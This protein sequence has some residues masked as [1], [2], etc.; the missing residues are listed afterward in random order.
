MAYLG[1]IREN[2]IS[3]EGIIWENDNRKDARYYWNGAFIDLCD[4]PGEDYAKTIFVTSGSGS[5]EPSTP[6]KVQNPITVQESTYTDENGN[7]YYV[8][9]AVSKQPV[10]SNVTIEMTIQDENGNE[11]EVVL[12]I[13]SGS[14]ASEPHRTGMMMMA[15]PPKVVTSDHNPKEDDK[16]EYDTVLP[17]EPIILPMAYS[18]TMLSGKIDT[19]S[20]EELIEKLMASGKIAMKDAVTSENFTVDFT[21][22]PVDGLETMGVIELTDA[23]INNASDI[24]LVT[25]K[26][27]KSIEQAEVAGINE[28][29]L[30]TKR[31]GNVQI[32][33]KPYDVWYKRDEGQTS[34][35][36]IC[37]SVNAGYVVGAEPRDYIIY[38]DNIN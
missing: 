2:S 29:S 35:S 7:T 6:S 26:A 19:I 32:D 17:E 15:R 16:F 24:I 38:Y 22:I 25:D 21:P 18:I 37:D 1:D 4:L 12:T 13:P 31:N 3:P 28:I 10:T 23:L 20:D 34:Q 27:I 5:N 8:Y 36:K 11:E 9:K 14:A 33:G 30:W